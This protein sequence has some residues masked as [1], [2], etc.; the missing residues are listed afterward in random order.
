LE[1]LTTIGGKLDTIEEKI[2][3][4]IDKLPDWGKIELIENKMAETEN[5]LSHE[6]LKRIPNFDFSTR[7][8]SPFTMLDRSSIHNVHQPNTYEPAPRCWI[9]MNDREGIMKLHDL[10]G[11][12]KLQTTT[13]FKYLYHGVIGGMKVHDLTG[14]LKRIYL[15]YFT[16]VLLRCDV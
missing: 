7:T 4:T 13:S 11:W 14:W 16:S 15:Y 5:M 6:V 2:H 3:E 8:S 10:N 9:Q 12:L 1:R